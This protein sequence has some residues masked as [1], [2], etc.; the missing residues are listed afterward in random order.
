M[1][2]QQ[3]KNPKIQETVDRIK[4]MTE[5]ISQCS[6][7]GMENDSMTSLI[8][9][10]YFHDTR[11]EKQAALFSALSKAQGEFPTIE[12]DKTVKVTTKKGGVYY[13]KYATY[14]AIKKAIK[15]PLAKHGL[16]VRHETFENKNI[17]RTI[18]MHEGGGF[19][20]S[21]MP[22]KSNDDPKEYGSMVTYK[23]RYNLCALLDIDSD[24]DDDA[25]AATGDETHP[26][27]REEYDANKNQGAEPKT[28]SDKQ[29]KRLF[30]I[31]KAA[32]YSPQ[33]VDN[34]VKK[35]WGLDSKSKLNKQQYDVVCDYLEKNPNEKPPETPQEE[36]EQAFDDS[37]NPFGPEMD[38]FT[39]GAY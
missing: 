28:V 23:R 27:S 32:G 7:L 24:E 14:S 12:K 6:S 39:G 15:E 17:L 18:L 22:L 31:T 11:Q 10:L 34:M 2:E 4:G 20:Y 1:S 25:G 16:S 8:K 37:D 30:A 9:E 29:L 33:W 13:F 21:D 35:K 5:V 19:V 3:I 36:I 26:V 38:D